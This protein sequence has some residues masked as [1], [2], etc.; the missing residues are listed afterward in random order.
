M[1]ILFT[2]VLILVTGC[3]ANQD[4]AL[5]LGSGLQQVE[6]GVVFLD[7]DDNLL[8]EDD[9]PRSAYLTFPVIPGGITGEVL[10]DSVYTLEVPTSSK[11]V[12]DLN[13]LSESILPFAVPMFSTSYTRNIAVLPKETKM[14][15][16]GTF[17][18]NTK[19]YEQIGATGLVSIGPEGVTSILLVYFDR[20]TKISGANSEGEFTIEYDVSVTGPGFVFLQATELGETHLKVTV[21]ESKQP[22]AISIEYATVREVSA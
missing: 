15:R 7:D 18:Y 21:H 12:L 3:V 11:F 19:T 5:S 22:K 1:K 10:T 14:L 8:V 2:I 20:A 16:L 13:S 6:L 17:A 9:L 4:M